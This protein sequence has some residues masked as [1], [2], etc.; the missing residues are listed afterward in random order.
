[1]KTKLLKAAL[2]KA[3]PFVAAKSTIPI[4]QNVA[5]RTDHGLLWL[6]ATNL[7]IAC[8]I[9][10]G[11]TS[12][13]FSTTVEHSILS[14]IVKDWGEEIYL[15]VEGASLLVSSTTAA[16]P[17]GV[18]ASG[19]KAT[20]PTIPY[21]DF[22][23]VISAAE[24][25]EVGVLSASTLSDVAARI[26]PS[27]YRYSDHDRP[28]LENVMMQLRDHDALFVA[29]DGFELAMLP[30]GKPESWQAEGA[31]EPPKLLVPPKALK[32][33]AGLSDR[34]GEKI[35]VSLRLSEGPQD[36]GTPISLRLNYTDSIT[37]ATVRLYTEG[38][39]PNWRQIMPQ[40]LPK[41]AFGSTKPMLRILKLLESI[42][43][44]H[45][46][47]ATSWAFAPSGLTIHARSEKGQATHA[48]PVVIIEPCKD[49][50]YN[51]AKAASLIA[52]AGDTVTFYIGE[53]T[54]PTLLEGDG[55]WKAVLMPLN[56]KP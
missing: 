11:Y 50:S 55:G 54:G 52:R 21:E 40:G 26:A 29:A 43:A 18:S 20:L 19:Q 27:V 32:P 34:P 38:N 46:N 24:T 25:Q 7:D 6:E 56:L 10:V 30:V 48:V 44:A 4:L 2:A 51:L 13:E 22:P 14:G 42:A 39:F 49:V 31:I 41:V 28:V 37:V 45:P 3:K 35:V 33:L 1:M 53:P 17:N 9:P 8:R 36:K 47:H 16:S 5:L 23:L 12:P 15:S